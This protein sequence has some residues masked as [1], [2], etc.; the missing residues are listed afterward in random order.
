VVKESLPTIRAGYREVRRIIRHGPNYPWRRY[1][2]PARILQAKTIRTDKSSDV[3]V[4]VLTSRKDWLSCLWS[5][6]SFYE[7]SGLRLPLLIY[8]DG[9][10]GERHAKDLGN[11]FPDARLVD[12]STGEQLVGKKI[13]RYP[14]CVRFRSV[15]PYARKIVDLPILCGSPFILMLDSDVLFLKRPVELMKHLKS[16]SADKFVFERD[17]QDSYFASTSDIKERFGVDVASRINVGI[18]FAD[19]SGFDLSE[20]N[21]WLGADGV[22]DHCW[23]EQTLWAMYA[24]RRQTVLLGEGYDVTI[25]PRIDANTVAKH[26]VTPIRDFL[27]IQGIPY[28]S[29]CLRGNGAEA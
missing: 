28:L 15:Q 27:Y 8:S 10:L 24:A 9:T 1:V 19:V 23:A 17:Y 21:E 26:Y 11:I 7:F 3:T 6:V 16:G 29:R 14:N 18:V 5:L 13:A 12:S 22:A 25:D 20:I 2:A 4:C